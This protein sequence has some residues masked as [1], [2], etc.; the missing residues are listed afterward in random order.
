MIVVEH[1]FMKYGKKQVLKDI[2]FEIKEGKIVGLLGANGAGKSTT[3]NILTG[4]LRPTEGKIVICGEDIVKNPLA[5]KKQIGYLPEVPPLYKDMKVEEYLNFAARLK[6][7]KK[8]K[9]EVTR[10]ISL[11]DLEEKRYEFIKKLSK[12]MQQR[13]GFAYT[14]LGNPPVLILDEPLVGLDPVESKRTRELIKSLQQDHVIVISSHI[15]REIEE[16]CNDILIL[17]D[18]SLVMD[19]STAKA[20]REK[21]RNEYRLTI[22]GDKNKI[23]ELL[24]SYDGFRQ[25]IYVAE[26]EDGVHEFAAKSKNTRDIRDSILG[27]LVSKKLNVYSIEKKEASLEDVF[28]EMNSKEEQ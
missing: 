19:Q 25:V 12:G 14:L 8:P 27:F 3:M 11:F 2:S 22:K 4:Y 18:G 15:L 16:L 13:A 21:N 28:L 20:K 5:A 7:I 24:Q 17:K 6:G 10:V 23:E 1:L 9:D 26:K